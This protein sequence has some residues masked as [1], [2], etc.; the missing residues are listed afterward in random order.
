MLRLVLFVTVALIWLPALARTQSCAPKGSKMIDRA[1]QLAASG[2]L[3]GAQSLLDEAEQTCGTSSVVMRKLAGVYREIL[4]DTAKADDFDRRAQ[5]LDGKRITAEQPKAENSVIKDKWA[6]CM[7]VSKFEHLKGAELQCPAKDA[8]DFAKALLDPAIG[9]F[10]D[11]NLHVHVLTDEKATLKGLLAGI[12]FIS[13]NARGDDLVVLYISSH[14]LSSKQDKNASG[15]AQT[16]Y[17]VTYD[18]DPN[19]L[20][21]SAFPMEDLRKVFDHLRAKRVVVFLDT[22]FSGDSFRWIGKGA[23]ALAI[24]P[25]MSYQRIVQGTGRALIVSSSGAQESWEGK[26]NSYFTESLI[27]AMKQHNGL[28]TVTQIFDTLDHD[29]PY[30]VLKAKNA[31]QTPLIWPQG[32]NVNIVIGAPIDGVTQ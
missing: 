12:D 13:A 30:K 3:R 6:L 22:C 2:D 16:G 17:V 31:T 19:A 15:D 24:D 25:D 7:G 1:I 21:S 32:Q 29:L 5:D 20:L 9:R 10:R 23:K 8:Q 26:N 28:G 11:D 14:G 4:L 18:T 27:D